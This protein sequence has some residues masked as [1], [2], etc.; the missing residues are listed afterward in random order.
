MRALLKEKSDGGDSPGETGRLEP[1]RESSEED[2]TRDEGTGGI[3]SGIGTLNMLHVHGH[4]ELAA[5]GRNALQHQDQHSASYAQAGDT[6]RSNIGNGRR[7]DVVDR[8]ILSMNLAR[9]LV[10]HYQNNLYPQ[11]PQVYIACPADELRETKPTLF[12]AV[13]AAGAESEDGALAT[14]LDH[15]ILQEYANRSVVQSEKSVEL[16]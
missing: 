2:M 11:Y 13:L 12:L 16:V 9:K 15:E 1:T 14:A 3:E 10:S 6:G 5:A 8:G 4:S 7:Q